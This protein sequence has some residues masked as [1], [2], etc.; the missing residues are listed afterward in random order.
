MYYVY[1]YLRENGT[2]YYIGKGTGNRI[3]QK[4]FHTCTVPPKERRQKLW[5]NL[6]EE[7]AC[8]IERDYIAY[9]GQARRGGLLANL[10]KGD[11]RFGAH[12]VGKK[13]SEETKAK[14]SAAHQKRLRAQEQHN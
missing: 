10:M 11:A 9:Y 12:R 14:M 8:V 5:T 2:P 4:T 1:A 3:N 7:E 6:T 13:H